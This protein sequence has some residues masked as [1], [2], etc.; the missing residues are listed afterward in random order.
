MANKPARRTGPEGAAAERRTGAHSQVGA[1]GGRVVVAR[2][3][4]FESWAAM[5]RKIDSLT[6]TPV[7]RFLIALHDGDTERVRELLADHAEVRAA[8]NEPISYFDSRPVARAKKNLPLLDVLLALAHLNLK[9]AWAGGFGLR[10][11]LHAWRRRL[12]ERERRRRLAAAHLGMFDRLRELVDVSR[13]RPRTRGDGKTP[14]HCAHPKSRHTFSSVSRRQRARRRSCRASPRS[15]FVRKRQ[16]ARLLVEVALA[17]HF[18]YRGRAARVALAERCLISRIADH[19][20][21]KAHVVGPQRKR[22][23]TRE[24]IGDRRGDIYRCVRVNVWRLKATPRR[25]TTSPN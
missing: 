2:G 12:I 11:R 25:T 15:T 21:D 16:V 4:G 1:T 8:V 13:R 5:K 20:A 18:S 3:Y 14:L 24:E 19:R 17:R 7:E 22:A 23:A 10:I 6:R 9:S